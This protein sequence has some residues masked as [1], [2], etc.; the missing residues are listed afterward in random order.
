MDE[1]ILHADHFLSHILTYIMELYGSSALKLNHHYATHIAEYVQDFGPSHS[2]WMFIFEQFN[3]VLKSYKANHHRDDELETMFFREFHWILQSSCMMCTLLQMQ[4]PLPSRVGEVM[5]KATLE[6]HGTVASLAALLKKLED[7][8]PDAGGNAIMHLGVLA[9]LVHVTIPQWAWAGFNHT[10]CE[11]LE[12]F[13]LDQ[14]L[15]SN[16]QSM[17]FAH[18]QWFKWLDGD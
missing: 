10:Y 7:A 5:H 15:K 6:E 18:V 1:E 11:I 14:D 9:S 16:G 17:I 12:I 13:Q 4:D 2:F 8:H 3:K